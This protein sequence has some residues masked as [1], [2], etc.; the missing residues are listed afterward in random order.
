MIRELDPSE[1]SLLVDSIPDEPQQ[2]GIID[3]A[4]T[5]FPKDGYAEF[6]TYIEDDGLQ[7]RALKKAEDEDFIKNWIP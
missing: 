2:M 6:V 5:W 4:F 3:L 7:L 1:V